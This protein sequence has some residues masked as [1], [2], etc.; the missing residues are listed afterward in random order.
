MRLTAIAG[1]SLLLAPAIHAQQAGVPPGTSH[2]DHQD[3]TAHVQADHF[4][5]RFDNAAEWAESFDDPARDEWQ[6]PSRVIDALDISPG[7]IVADIGA[8]TGY[9][10]VRLARATAKPIVY[11]VDIESSM[12]EHVRHRAMAEGLSN[13]TA[14]QAAADHPSLPEPVD[15]ALIVDTFHHI[16]NRVA[17][18]TTLR[19]MLKAGGR[20]AIVDF[21]KDSPAGPPVEFRFT[22]EQIRA[23]LEAAG[24][25]LVGSHDF[26]PRQVFLLFGVN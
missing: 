14:V 26:L 10:T 19:G 15:V 3:H 16:P 4:A 17:Y 9:F 18:F 22:P 6:M 11:A 1:L 7:Q 23:E 5:H 21:R 20:V 25:S 8:G 2:Q 12:I 24:F 13:V